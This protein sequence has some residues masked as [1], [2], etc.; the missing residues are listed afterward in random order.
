MF[1]TLGHGKRKVS[2]GQFIKECDMRGF[3][4]Q[5]QAVVACLHPAGRKFLME[6]DLSFLD[7]WRP[8]AWLVARPNFQAAEDFITL[9]LGRHGHYVK[10]WRCAM[11][12]DSSNM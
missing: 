3:H 6:E 9:L 11:D 10:A 7:V 2:L 5:V 12:K 4:R 8:S 1:K